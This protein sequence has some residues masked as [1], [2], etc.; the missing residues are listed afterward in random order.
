MGNKK[1]YAIT[2]D[3]TNNAIKT[4][5]RTW[6]RQ[7]IDLYPT[8]NPDS[9]KVTTGSIRR[10]LVKDGWI[11]EESSLEEYVIKP[12]GNN[13]VEYAASIIDLL[14]RLENDIDVENEELYA[15]S[16]SLEKDLQAA[17]RRNIATLKSG[18]KIIDGGVEK[19]TPAGRI[20][21]T[22]QD[23]KGTV[24]VIELKAG[25]AK[26]DVIAQVLAY[27]TAV[28]EEGNLDVKGIIVA[29]EFPDRVKLAA[30][31]LDFM[32]LIEYGFQFSFTKA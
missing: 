28:K 27:I 13:S 26:P 7:N 17:L 30:K 18:L 5:L 16:F 29:Q 14:E 3:I 8:L 23:D 24:F 25:K 10:A 9:D 19:N 22:A 6:I 20:D 15:I 21:I 1:H 2:P 12:D 31:A 11:H 4:P 32:E